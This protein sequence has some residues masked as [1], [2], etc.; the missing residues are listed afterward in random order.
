MKNRL[1]NILVDC[2]CNTLHVM[3]CSEHQSTTCSVESLLRQYPLFN[4]FKAKSP[5]V[6]RYYF[7]QVAMW[8]CV[9]VDSRCSFAD[10]CRWEV[11]G[12]SSWVPLVS[13]DAAAGETVPG[14]TGI[15]ERGAEEIGTAEAPVA[16]M[17]HGLAAT[18]CSPSDHGRLVRMLQ[19]KS[20]SKMLIPGPPE[21]LVE[22]ALYALFERNPLT[23]EDWSDMVDASP[24]K[25]QRDF[26]RFGGL[27]PKKLVALY[28][29]YR[30]AFD[31]VEK[32][33]NRHRGVVSAYVVDGHSRE[34]VMEY[35]LS[36]RCQLLTTQ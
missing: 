3:L 6:M 16:R 5:E 22:R 27:S 8:H 23:V 36:R 19:M 26:K 24:R 30:I 25:F 14:S 12:L 34:R 7:R 13:L 29:A 31:V 17:S 20:I 15:D 4:L 11:A 33:E 28:H 1:E 32:R 2:L 9:L 10:E 35:V 18:S 21:G